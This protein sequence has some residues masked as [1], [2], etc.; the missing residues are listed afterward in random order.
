M[1]SYSRVMQLDL[2][3]SSRSVQ[4]IGRR[5]VS[6][7]HDRCDIRT[8]RFA[9]LHPSFLQISYRKS[10]RLSVCLSVRQSLA[11]CQNDSSYDHG[12]FTVG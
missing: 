10:V 4:N 6:I 2:L 8:V 5:V 1:D 11:L 12:V 3:S 9:K 7:W